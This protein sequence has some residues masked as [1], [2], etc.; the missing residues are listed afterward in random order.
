MEY[1]KCAYFKCTVESWESCVVCDRVY[2]REHYETHNCGESND[3][4]R[5]PECM[6]FPDKE[7][8]PR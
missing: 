4:D 5:E 3:V 1:E 6:D 2:C 7:G 8:E